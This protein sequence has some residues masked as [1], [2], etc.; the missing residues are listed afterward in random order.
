MKELGGDHSSF[1]REKN[2]WDFYHNSAYIIDTDYLLDYTGKMHIPD[3]P[4]FKKNSI[5][6]PGLGF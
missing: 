6:P 2:G 4:I 5:S 1:F 3:D